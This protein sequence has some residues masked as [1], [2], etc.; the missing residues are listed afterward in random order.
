MCDTS[1]S[2]HDK[3]LARNILRDLVPCDDFRNISSQLGF[4]PASS[5]VDYVEHVQSHMR[6]EKVIPLTPLIAQLSDDAAQM[7]A[8]VQSVVHEPVCEEQLGHYLAISRGAAFS[9][10]TQLVDHGYLEV[11]I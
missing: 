3:R 8:G 5:D 2:L 6:R 1:A 10:I 11:K 9:V 4:I 7:M